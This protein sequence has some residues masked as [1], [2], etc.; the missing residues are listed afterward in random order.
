[1][2]FDQPDWHNGFEHDPDEAVRVRVRL[3]QET[4]ASGEL[5]VATH[6]PFPSVGRLAVNGEAFRWIPA[7]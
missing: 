7:I 3:V 1:M 4:A 5:F 2:A 6:L